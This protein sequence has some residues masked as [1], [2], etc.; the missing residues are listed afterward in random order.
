MNMVAMITRY[1]AAINTQYNPVFGAYNFT[2]DIQTAALQISTTDIADKRKEVIE[3]AVPALKTI[4]KILRAERAGKAA[5]GEDVTEYNRFRLAGGQTG[6]RDQF[7][8]TAERAAAIQS[9]ID[10]SSWSESKMGK[11]ISANGRLKVPLETARKTL[12]PLF[13]LL[14]DYNQTLENSV[15]FSAFKV[16]K[17]KY[18]D[19]GFSLDDAEQ[20]ASV[21]SKEITV[22]FNQKGA[23]VNTIGALYAFFNASVQGTYM[24]AKTYAGP[25]GK[26]IIQGSLLW[27]SFQA[28]MLAMAGFDDDEPPEFVK[29][30]N[31]IIPYGDGKYLAIPMPLGFNVLPTLSRLATEAVLTGGKKTPEKVL[32]ALDAALDM[33][34][35]IGNAG[36]SGQTVAPTLLDPI[37]AIIENKNWTGQ[38]IAREDFS[39]LN[40]TPGFTR[41]RDSATA[42]SKGFAEFLNTVSGGNESRRGLIS[43]T[44]DQLEYLVGQLTGGVGRETMKLGKTIEATVTGE[45]LPFYSVPLIG[46]FHGNVNEMASISSAFYRNLTELNIQKNEIKNLRENKGD[47][48]AYLAENPEARLAQMATAQYTQIKNLRKLRQAALERGDKERAKKIEEAIKARMINLNERYDKLTD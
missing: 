44:A 16:A 25:L 5:K 46:R 42:I 35:P 26:K 4:F 32:A 38:D 18:L 17:Q 6:Y 8:Q 1:F 31:F 40:P 34:N 13:G 41:S 43:P 10:P 2:R 48:Q 37:I 28:L 33:F 29:Q 27:G 36:L 22:N 21:I 24:M 45:E 12:A 47:L 20:K 11:V 3:G 7:S 14:S 19:Q 30:R 39:G 9:L 15:R 23:K